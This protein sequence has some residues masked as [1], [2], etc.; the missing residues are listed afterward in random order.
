M[1]IFHRC[2]RLYQIT[3]VSCKYNLVLNEINEFLVFTQD[4]N[5]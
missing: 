5:T 4:L 2:I 3:V 1:K